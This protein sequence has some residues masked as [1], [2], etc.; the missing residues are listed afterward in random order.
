MSS[1]TSPS[2]PFNCKN[3][4][5]GSWLNLIKTCLYPQSSSLLLQLL[6]GG[7]NQ[8]PTVKSS[9]IIIFKYSGGPN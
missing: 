5:Q 4:L 8:S 9:K 7:P 2:F 3:M 1:F 6:L